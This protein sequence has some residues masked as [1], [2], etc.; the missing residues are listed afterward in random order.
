LLVLASVVVG[1]PLLLLASAGLAS[2]TAAW[3]QRAAFTPAIP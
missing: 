2:M 3:T 1:Y